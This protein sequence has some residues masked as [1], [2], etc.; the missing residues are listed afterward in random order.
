MQNKFIK[1]RLDVLLQISKQS[2]KK[3]KKILQKDLSKSKNKM[4]NAKCK[5]K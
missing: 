1:K 2:F 5:T 4:F 3:I